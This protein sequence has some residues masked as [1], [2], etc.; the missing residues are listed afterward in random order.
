MPYRESMQMN[1]AQKKSTQRKY[2]TESDKLSKD[3]PKHEIYIEKVAI[4]ERKALKQVIMV[5]YK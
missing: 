1:I 2:F 3:T 4:Y 5:M